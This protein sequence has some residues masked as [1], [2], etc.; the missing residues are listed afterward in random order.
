MDCSTGA[1]WDT[2]SAHQTAQ[3]TARRSAYRKAAQK[4]KH[5]AHRT[6]GRKGRHSGLLMDSRSAGR[7]V[8]CWE[9]MKAQKTDKH[10]VPH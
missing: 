2:N 8:L 9:Y 5:W 3:Q 1:H 4:G 10:S 7:K 6:G